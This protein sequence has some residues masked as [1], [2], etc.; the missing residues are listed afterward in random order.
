MTFLSEIYKLF[1]NDR[2]GVAGDGG[3]TVGQLQWELDVYHSLRNGLII[4]LFTPTAR[5]LMALAAV[6]AI[7]YA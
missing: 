3:G 5:G 6:T 7:D 4:S 1:S 2:P